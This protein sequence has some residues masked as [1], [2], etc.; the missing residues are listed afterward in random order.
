MQQA[1]RLGAK[2]MRE[3]TGGPF[4]AVIV[5]NAKVIG[6]GQNRVLDQCDPTAHAEMVAIRHACE[7]IE[8]FELKA[9]EIYTSCEPCPMCLGAVY[10]SRLERVYYAANRADAAAIGFDDHYFYEEFDK[11]HSERGVRMIE[12]QREEAMVIF[13]EWQSMDDKRIY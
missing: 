1:I 6:I 4:G 7:T 5:Q 9:C 3:G 13:N 2:A 10:W 8:S 12:M 11:N